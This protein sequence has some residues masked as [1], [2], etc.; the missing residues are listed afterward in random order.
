MSDKQSDTPATDPSG[1]GRRQTERRKAQV[2]FD[3]PDRRK[4]DRRTGE[5]RRTTKRGDIGDDA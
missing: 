5:D 1:G 4:A 2:P 3:G